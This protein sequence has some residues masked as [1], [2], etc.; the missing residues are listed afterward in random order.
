MTIAEQIKKIIDG[1]KEKEK[2]KKVELREI[3]TELKKYMKCLE[4]L[5]E[6]NPDRPE[7]EEAKNGK[8]RNNS[9]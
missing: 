8:P 1:L 7:V 2:T 6:L 5:R 4:P 3:Q 9:A